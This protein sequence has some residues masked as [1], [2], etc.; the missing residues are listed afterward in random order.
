MPHN[1][2]VKELRSKES[3]YNHIHLGTNLPVME[4]F[5]KYVYRE[6]ERMNCFSIILFDES[7]NDIIGHSMLYKWEKTLY[8]AFI[9]A[10]E[11]N[12]KNTESLIEEIKKQA[13]NLFCESIFGPVNLPPYI[14]GFGF[15]DLIRDDSIFAMAPITNPKYIEY[16]KKCGFE[17]KQGINHYK[18]PMA[19]IPYEKKWDVRSADLNK[20]QEWRDRFLELQMKVFPQSI[21]ITP[22][23][24]KSFPDMIEFIHEFSFN[25]IKFAY[26]DGEIIGLGWASPNPY[27][28]GDN[29]K[30]KSLVLFGGA[31]EP[32]YQAKGI[33]TQ[34][35]YQWIDEN[36][37]LGV[38]HGESCVSEDNIAGTKLMEHWLGKPTRHHVMMQF[39]FKDV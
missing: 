30:S 33:L 25:A 21:Q 36:R 7:S 18:I 13:K 35:F 19:P 16:F 22:N 24:A 9:Y 20:P 2:F 39:N 38:T 29:G 23:R 1:Y 14:F 34:I 31:V 10:K 3:V 6:I 28:L 12:F 37:Q 8:F 32:E 5:K 17:V 27:D 4:S 11:E 26:I 15:S